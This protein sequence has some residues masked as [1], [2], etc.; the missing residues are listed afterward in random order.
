METVQLKSVLEA[1]MEKERQTKG[2]LK[3]WVAE[4]K[5]NLEG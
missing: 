2:R 3:Q 1:R 4:A 5:Q